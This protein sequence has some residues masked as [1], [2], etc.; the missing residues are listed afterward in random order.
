M[1]GARIAKAMSKLAQICKTLGQ[2][3][4]SHSEALIE[5]LGPMSNSHPGQAI[6]EQY[7]QASNQPNL[8]ILTAD[9]PSSMTQRIL[10]PL[11]QMISPFMTDSDMNIFTN[12]NADMDF[13]LTDL[14]TG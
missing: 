11:S 7:Q 9:T 1:T 10:D 12:L 3:H 13:G 14:L 8:D 6:P 4:P 2:S 5:A